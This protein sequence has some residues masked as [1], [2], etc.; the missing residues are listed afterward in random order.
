MRSACAGP[1]GGP[2]TPA[3]DRG[4]RGS[5][6][7]LYVRHGVAGQHRLHGGSDAEG[8]D[9]EPRPLPT[10]SNLTFVHAGASA[11]RRREAVAASLR[12]GSG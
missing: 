8:P 1:A 3:W 2:A 12:S 10:L 5:V 7:N 6:S 11:K 4:W 9:R